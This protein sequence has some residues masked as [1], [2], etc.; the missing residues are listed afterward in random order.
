[1]VY[2]VG[3]TREITLN[4]FCYLTYLTCFYLN[5]K[6]FQQRLKSIS[7]NGTVLGTC[8]CY[9]QYIYLFINNCVTRRLHSENYNMMF[10][11]I[12][13]TKSNW[14]K[15]SSFPCSSTYQML[16]ISHFLFALKNVFTQPFFEFHTRSKTSPIPLDTLFHIHGR[17]L[18]TV[19]VNFL[20]CFLNFLH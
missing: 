4:H 6:Y 8:Y 18:I 17:T 3:F 9:I 19:Q 1:M 13:S 20:R 16:P 12:C 7:L 11:H 2:L 14:K 15:C 10:Q 5:F